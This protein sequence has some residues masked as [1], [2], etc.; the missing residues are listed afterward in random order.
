MNIVKSCNSKT[1]SNILM[2]QT[3]QDA[4]VQDQFQMFE[5]AEGSWIG[6]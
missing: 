6:S 4:K 2:A 5:A 1:R 3:S